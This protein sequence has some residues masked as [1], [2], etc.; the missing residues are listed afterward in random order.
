MFQGKWWAA[1]NY[2]KTKEHRSKFNRFFPGQSPLQGFAQA[3]VR[4]TENNQAVKR[5]LNQIQPYL[6]TLFDGTDDQA[7]QI[8][9]I[10]AIG[11]IKCYVDG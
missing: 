4:L 11:P 8:W 10:V 7:K 6:D 3:G 9:S 1:E 5:A 2:Y